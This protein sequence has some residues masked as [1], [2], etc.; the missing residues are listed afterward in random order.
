M[1]TE[2]I[3][4]DKGKTVSLNEVLKEKL[5]D[6]EFR[7]AYEELESIYEAWRRDRSLGRPYS[8]IRKDLVAEG[9]LDELDNSTDTG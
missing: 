8:E 7:Q 2:T 5:R 6:P 4:N 1:L 3:R 9:L